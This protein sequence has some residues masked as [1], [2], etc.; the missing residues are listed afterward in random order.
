MA[1]HSTDGQ[2][3]GRRIPHNILFEGCE[4]QWLSWGCRSSFSSLVFLEYFTWLSPVCSIICCVVFW[5]LFTRS[6]SQSVLFQMLFDFLAFKNEISFWR[7]RKTM[8]GIS[9]SSVAW[10]AFSQIIIFLYL[11]D[12]NTSMLVLVPAGVGGIIEVRCRGP[13]S[14]D[15]KN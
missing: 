8:A 11:M 1:A 10:R 13:K 15:K 14:W 3:C 9:S 12:E 6:V 4:W 2:C 7:G 5:M